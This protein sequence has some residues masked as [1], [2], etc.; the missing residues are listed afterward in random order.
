MLALNAEHTSNEIHCWRN[1]CYLRCGKTVWKLLIILWKTMF[2]TSSSS[3]RLSCSH[4]CSQPSSHSSAA[5]PFIDIFLTAVSY[6]HLNA[7]GL[8]DQCKLQMQTF[9]IFFL[10]L[11]KKKQKHKLVCLWRSAI[12]RRCCL[13]W[14]LSF[15]PMDFHEFKQGLNLQWPALKS[16]ILIQMSNKSTAQKN[17]DCHTCRNCQLNMHAWLAVACCQKRCVTPTAVQSNLYSWQIGP[18]ITQTIFWGIA[19]P[20]S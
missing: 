17:P 20:E 10:S 7:D 1:V 15:T 9:S 3:H 19:V 8:E 4:C 13:L 16:T 6:F 18:V 5:L 14:E 11:F 2:C 12:C